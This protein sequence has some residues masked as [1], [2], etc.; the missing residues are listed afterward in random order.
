[1][2][3]Q[4]AAVPQPDITSA[5]VA[6]MR[7]LYG[8]HPQHSDDLARQYCLTPEQLRTIAVSGADQ[9]YRWIAAAERAVI[10]RAVRDGRDLAEVAKEHAIGRHSV[11]RIARMPG[12]GWRRLYAWVDPA[13]GGVDPATPE[14]VAAVPTPASVEQ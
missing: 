3:E 11:R 4:Q 14:A 13:G 1:M 2:N 5:Q 8:S 12:G 6:E 7:A 9:Q 10:R